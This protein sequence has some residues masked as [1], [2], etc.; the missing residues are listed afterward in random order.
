MSVTVAG[1]GRV[2]LI[3]GTR[4]ATCVQTCSETFP[5]FTT[6]RF[7]TVAEPGFELDGWDGDCAGAGGCAVYVD[8]PKSVVVRFVRERFQVRGRSAARDA[9]RETAWP[10]PAL[11]CLRRVGF[12]PSARRARRPRLGFVRWRGACSGSRACVARV[13]APTV[14]RTQFVRR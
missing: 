6:G 8:G 10:A 1:G 13:A 2:R 11:L 14:I 7:A 9:S 12:A 3:G 4:V 5:L